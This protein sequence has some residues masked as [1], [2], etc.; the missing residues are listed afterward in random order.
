ME[1]WHED[2]PTRRALQ[3]FIVLTR[4][5]DSVM[6]HARQDI[7]RHR[8]SGS[9]FGVL[10]M[11]YHKGP[12]PLGVL[13][14]RILIT[15]GS[16]TYVVDQL[17]KRGLVQRVACPTDRRVTYADLT[18]AGRALIREIFPDHAEVLRQAVSGLT[19]DE[20]ETAIALLKKLGL[21]AKDALP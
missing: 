5:C 9:E 17:Q 18:D 11:L 2:E 12:T 13:A 16:L 21:A 3:L 20:Q 8:L 7:Q 15:S 6:E 4:C 19:P 1:S 14:E 10:E